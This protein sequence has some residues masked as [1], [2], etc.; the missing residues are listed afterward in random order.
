MPVQAALRH[1]QKEVGDNAKDKMYAYVGGQLM[2]FIRENP[3]KAPLFT[4]PGKSINGSFEAMRK[5]AEKVRV[6]NTA[7]LDPDEGMAIVLEY[8]GIKQ[9][10]PAPAR[11][12]VDVGLS[13]DLDE[14]LL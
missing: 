10:K 4:A 11:E 12:T 7:A 1:I 14:L 5:V 6:G 13:V 8:Y 2:K 9:E 3:D